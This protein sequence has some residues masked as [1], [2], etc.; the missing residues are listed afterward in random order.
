[1]RLV[2]V[3][4]SL[5]EVEVLWLLDAERRCVPLRSRLVVTPQKADEGVDVVCAPGGE[6][7]LEFRAP[8]LQQFLDSAGSSGCEDHA[9]RAF[10]VWVGHSFDEAQPLEVVD[11]PADRPLSMSSAVATSAKRAWSLA[12][13]QS[14]T[15]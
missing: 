5:R 6:G 8:A 7:S 14:R 4:L 10:V 13:G 11:L 9:V 2:W 3:R 15:A 1:M 12:A